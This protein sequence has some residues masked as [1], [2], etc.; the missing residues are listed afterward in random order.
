MKLTF[1]ISATLIGFANAIALSKRSV[2]FV[3]GS[4][5]VRGVNTGGWLVLEPWITPSIF[6]QL[7]GHETVDE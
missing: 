2:D 7:P 3:W 5:K 4:E 6:Q 1:A